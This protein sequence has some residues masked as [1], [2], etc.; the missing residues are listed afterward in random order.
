MTSTEQASEVL[1]GFGTGVGS[2]VTVWEVVC[3]CRGVAWF[4]IVSMND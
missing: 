3:V 1:V 4:A 2:N